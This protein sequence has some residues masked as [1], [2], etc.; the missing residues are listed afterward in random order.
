MPDVTPVRQELDIVE[1]PATGL[2]AYWL[3]LKKLMDDRKGGKIVIEEM[4][5][6]TEPTIRH[7]LD[8]AFGSS[9]PEEVLRRI[10]LARRQMVLG[11]LRTKLDCMARTLSAMVAADNPQRVLSLLTALYPLPPVREAEAMEAV[12]AT[13]ERVRRGD[14]EEGPLAAVDHT[15][16]PGALLVRLMYCLVTARREG[17][18]ACRRLIGHTRSLF[19]AEGLA[20]VADGFEE[21]FVSRRL[22]LH[23]RSI[24]GDT[25]VKLRMAGELCLGIKARYPYEDLWRLARTYLPDQ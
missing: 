2:A 17:R 5:A 4:A 15:L 8:A 22:A 9:L 3:S 16:A 24:L 12:Y 18:E 10:F 6:V 11:D 7:L 23:R 14:I 19:F 1:M 13:V 20:L 21:S 25:D